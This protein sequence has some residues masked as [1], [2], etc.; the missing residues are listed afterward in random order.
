MCLSRR[1][2]GGITKTV[3][4]K[5]IFM[6]NSLK[7]II[8]LFSLNLPVPFFKHIYKKSKLLMMLMKLMPV[9]LLEFESRV[10]FLYE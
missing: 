3:I 1:L 9:E 2:H 7:V 10:R 8:R 4:N 5:N 6:Q